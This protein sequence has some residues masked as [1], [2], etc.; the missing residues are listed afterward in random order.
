MLDNP[1]DQ[2]VMNA[3]TISTSQPRAEANAAIIPWLLAGLVLLIALV[4]RVLNLGAFLSADEAL[5]YVR[6]IA[7]W[8]ALKGFDFAGTYQQIHPNVTTMWITG[9]PLKMAGRLGVDLSGPHWIPI[10]RLPV[11]VF[12]ATACIALYGLL[13]RLFSWRIAFIIGCVVALDPFYVAN[14]RTLHVHAS[15]ASYIILSYVTLLVALQQQRRL[16]WMVLSG[17]LAGLA[18]LT[19]VNALSLIPVVGATMLLPPAVVLGLLTGKWK[20]AL[21]DLGQRAVL[22]AGVVWVGACMFVFVVGWPAMW[23]KPVYTLQ[24]LATGVLWG[25]NTPHG[26]DLTSQEI[27][28]MYGNNPAALDFIKEFR[29]QQGFK[30][31]RQFFMGQV[32]WT[33]GYLFYPLTW[34]YRSTPLTLFMLVAAVVL[35]TIRL[36]Q[37][38][39]REYDL[40]SLYLLAFALAFMLMLGLSAKQLQRY[41]L[42]SFLL[43]DVVVGLYL[44]NFAAWLTHVIAKRWSLSSATAKLLPV[45]FSLG[46]IAT[47]HWLPYART[48]PYEI[49]YYQPLLGGHAKAQDVLLLGT[50]E[51]L[52][53]VADYLNQ[54][55]G[56]D[57]SVATRYGQYFAPFYKGETDFISRVETY[58]ASD[59]DYILVYIREKQRRRNPELAP[60][61]ASHTPEHIVTLNTLDYVWIYRWNDA[62]D[63]LK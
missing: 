63:H 9:L 10:A 39:L 2:F 43:I 21:S 1:S 7:F 61:L 14:S 29:Q 42:P 50:G 35:L 8:D 60:F 40:H 46:L 30:Y 49:T 17:F 38:S 16:R 13:S 59:A 6:S 54:T 34:L 5:W 4:P 57:V 23:V 20:T 28:V 62:S 55:Y 25:V 19:N 47:L 56:G 48:H 22:R 11:A 58:D 44:A 51:G 45:L 36:W 27:E 53:L 31:P 33:P 12:T 52:S 26:G 3:K 24:R 18:L 41:L 32:V 15:S 37:R